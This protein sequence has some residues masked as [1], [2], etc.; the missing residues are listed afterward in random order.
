MFCF[1]LQKE[2]NYDTAQFYKDWANP[3]KVLI[4]ERKWFF[5]I[6]ILWWFHKSQYKLYIALAHRNTKRN[7]TEDMNSNS[8][9]IIANNRMEYYY[10]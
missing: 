6:I 8:K 5:W 4:K 7:V 3:P 2:R 1:I 9:L 10:L